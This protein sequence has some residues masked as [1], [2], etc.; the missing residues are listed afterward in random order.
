[1]TALALSITRS[2][3]H[4]VASDLVTKRMQGWASRIG[5]QL[6]S[7]LATMPKVTKTP[8][9]S[10]TRDSKWK[11][12]CVNFTPMN[13]VARAS[14]ALQA[15]VKVQLQVHPS[16]QKNLRYQVTGLALCTTPSFAHKVFSLKKAPSN[17]KNHPS[18][19][20]PPFHGPSQYYFS[21]RSKR[22]RLTKSAISPDH[23]PPQYYFSCRSKRPG[24]TKRVIRPDLIPSLAWPTPIW[25]L[26]SLKKD[27][28]NKKSH[29]SWSHPIPC[30]VHPKLFFLFAQK[31]PSNEK[32]HPSWSHPIPCMAHPEMIFLFAQKG[33]V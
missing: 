24:L 8:P 2:R 25:F 11:C 31:D 21:F 27:W 29:P 28:S 18:W 5:C 19:S 6:H 13:K 23:G 17:E 12:D 4:T 1:M 26:F 15:K 14:I 7:P 22:P 30:M 3:A 10:P 32:S 16:K 33:P 20:L 9:P